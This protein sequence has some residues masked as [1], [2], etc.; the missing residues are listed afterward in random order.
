MS[1]GVSEL[2]RFTQY[3]VDQGYLDGEA[4]RRVEARADENCERIGQL[5]LRRRYVTMRQMLEL[6]RQQGEQLETPIGELAVRAGYLDRAQLDELLRLQLASRRHV[7]ELVVEEGVLDP[8]A[9][10]EVMA[11]YIKWLD[12]TDVDAGDPALASGPD[13]SAA[14]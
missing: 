8:V 5:M 10:L 4:A 9:A 3:L 14:A 6:L 7:A 13:V 1:R 11:T 2:G 12:A